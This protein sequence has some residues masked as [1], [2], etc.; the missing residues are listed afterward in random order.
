SRS[1]SG[2]TGKFTSNVWCDVIDSKDSTVLAEYTDGFYKGTPC[3]TVNN[4]G[5]GKVYYIGCNMDID[6]LTPL[7]NY[8]SLEADVEK[9]SI[10]PVPGVE[11][12]IRKGPER[13]YIFAMNHTNS[14]VY[15]PIDKE[16]TDKLSGST[17]NGSIRLEPYGVVVLY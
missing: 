10:R 17:F 5:K 4:F 2:M 11:T 16:Y 13:H 1:S 6:D 14:T 9:A 7:F 3:I 12:V 15:I 8:I